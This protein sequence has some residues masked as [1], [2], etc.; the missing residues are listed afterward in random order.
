VLR[1]KLVTLLLAVL[2]LAATL[3]PARQI[4]SEFM[5]TLNE[6]TL[7]YMPTTLPGMS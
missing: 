3:V 6:G 7:F 4:G 5:P 2:A 1:F